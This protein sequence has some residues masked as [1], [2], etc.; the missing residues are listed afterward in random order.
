[1]GYLGL[2][3][4]GAATVAIAIVLIRLMGQVSVLMDEV[5]E[6]VQKDVHRDIMPNVTAITANIKTISDDAAE[7]TT[8]VTGTV[9]KVSAVVGGIANKVESPAIKAVGVLSGV[10]AGARVLRGQKDAPVEKK[11]RGGLFGMGKK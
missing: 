6:M 2:F 3:L 8:N 5:N 9:N 7:T 1:M 4:F 11:K 10:M